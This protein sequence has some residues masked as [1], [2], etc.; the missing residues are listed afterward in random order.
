MRPPRSSRFVSAWMGFRWPSS[1][2]T[3][4]LVPGEGGVPERI[5]YYST[6]KTFIPERLSISWHRHPGE[7]WGQ[8]TTEIAGQGF[9]KD[10]RALK[11]RSRRSDGS[12]AHRW[13]LA[14]DDH[15]RPM[16][17][18]M[19]WEW[20]RGMIDAHDPNKGWPQ[21]VTEEAS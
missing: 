1:W 16:P 8:G 18:W 13:P 10:G 20:V 7:E 21:S 4:E 14:V 2:L 17:A 6:G 15:T 9:S 11:G 5:D 3:V 12:L 19:S